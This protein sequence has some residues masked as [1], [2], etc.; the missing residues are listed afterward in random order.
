MVALSVFGDVALAGSFLATWL[1]PDGR[2]ARPIGFLLLMMLFEFIAIHSSAFMGSVWFNGQNLAKRSKSMLAIAGLYFLFVGGYALGFGSWV[3]VIAFS[4]LVVNRLM[5][6]VLDPDPDGATK[7]RVEAG[8]ARATA[9]YVGFAG[10]TTLLPVPAFGIDDRAI[11]QADLPSTGLWIDE[12]QRVIAF[13]F[14]YFSFTAVFETRSRWRQ[15]HRDLG[16]VQRSVA[17]HRVPGD[18]LDNE[19]ITVRIGD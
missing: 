11:Q 5:T 12:P 2:W 19:G 7:E 16:E 6:L 8:W 13:G 9:F 3:P 14:L 4:A 17:E 10:I 18:R 15:A 1:E